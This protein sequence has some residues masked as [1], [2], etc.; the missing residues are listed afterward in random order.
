[1]EPYN[2]M[3]KCI[4]TISLDFLIVS[5]CDLDRTANAH[6]KKMADIFCIVTQKSDL[7]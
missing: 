4:S 6:A 5:W 3:N 1:M 7:K 2:W